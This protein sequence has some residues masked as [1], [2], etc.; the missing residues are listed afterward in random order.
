MKN[1]TKLYSFILLELTY[2]L[3]RKHNN[4]EVLYRTKT[5]FYVMLQA[6]DIFIMFINICTFVKSH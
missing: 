3:N 5:G 4:E 2:N 6:H 1:K